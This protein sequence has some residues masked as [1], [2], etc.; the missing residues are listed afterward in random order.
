MPHKLRPIIRGGQTAK[1]NAAR[2]VRQR[3]EQRAFAATIADPTQPVSTGVSGGPTQQ[4]HGELVRFYSSMAR[5]Q[6]IAASRTW[7]SPISYEETGYILGFL[8]AV[9]DP[10]MRVIFKIEG[11]DR[12]EIMIHDHTM[13]ETA[14]LGLGMTY[15]EFISKNPVG[16]GTS[17]DIRGTKHST[18]PFLSRAKTT[19]TGEETIYDRIK[20]TKDDQWI[21]L[22]FDPE[23]PRKYYAFS[24]DV[25]NTNGEGDRLVHEIYVD[26]MVVV[27]AYETQISKRTFAPKL[28]DQSLVETEKVRAYSGQLVN[29]SDEDA[30]VPSPEPTIDFASNVPRMNPVPEEDLDEE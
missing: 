9:N 5:K 16:G 29:P 4:Y 17:R 26:R 8:V 23:L 7:D 22:E 11:E 10:E 19:F 12:T 20:G 30:P 21:V 15:G 13:T 3:S 1:A 27:S 25:E 6:T 18:R 14:L 24:L 28:L 2:L